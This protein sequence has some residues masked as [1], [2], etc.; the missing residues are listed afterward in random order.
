MTTTSLLTTDSLNQPLGPLAPHFIL[1]LY[2]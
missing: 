2:T 1:D